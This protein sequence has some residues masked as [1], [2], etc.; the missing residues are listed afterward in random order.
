ME[1]LDD[2]GPIW[3]KI[4]SETVTGYAMA[5]DTDTGARWLTKPEGKPASFTVVIPG[6]DAATA[7]ALLET[8]PGAYSLDK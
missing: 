1:V 3:W 6:L 2:T 4:R 8:Y 7:T 5:V